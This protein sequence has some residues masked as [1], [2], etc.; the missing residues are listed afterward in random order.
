MRNKKELSYFEHILELRK[1]FIYII[2]FFIIS[3]VLSYFYSNKFIAII[4]DILKEEL[5][6]QK[7]TEAFTT[8]IKVAIYLA[9]FLTVPFAIFQITFFLFPALTKKEKMIYIVTLFSFFILFAIGFIFAFK[10]VLPLSINFLKSDFLFTENIKRI[11]NYSDFISFFFL[12]LIAFGIAF[13]FPV[14][15]IMLLY[16][17]VIKLS[18]LTKNFKYFVILIFVLSAIITP[19]DVVSQVLMALP[20]L[21]LYILTI[22]IAFILRIGA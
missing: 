12:F 22:I 1:R 15:F 8:K 16:F 5:Y 6:V 20:L 21:V 7:I 11:I 9:S 13:Q 2:I 17:R 10:S 4:I 14:V 3:A 18:F 19:P